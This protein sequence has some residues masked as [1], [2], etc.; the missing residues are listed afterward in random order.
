MPS[1]VQQHGAALAAG[2]VP[3]TTPHQAQPERGE[4]GPHR[5]PGGAEGPRAELGDRLPRD[6]SAQSSARVG[7]TAIR[8][9][10]VDDGE[11]CDAVRGLLACGSRREGL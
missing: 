10:V 9:A 1:G 4:G 3:D 5:R 2:G 11:G 6:V 7:G 8:G